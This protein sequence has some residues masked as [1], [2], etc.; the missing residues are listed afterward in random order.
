MTILVQGAMDSELDILKDY[1]KPVEVRT[2][3]GYEFYLCEYSNNKIILSK[4][5]VGIINAAIASTIGI[6]EFHPELVINQ[7]CAGAHRADIKRGDLIIGEKTVYINNF[8]TQAKRLG[9]GSDSLSWRPSNNN[10]YVI[11]STP[12][13]VELA[14]SVDYDGKKYTG[15]LGSGDLFSKEVDRINYM[16]ALFGELSEDMEAVATMKVCEA[17][18]IDKIAL[19]IISNNEITNE[20]FDRSV[21]QT[22]QQFVISFIDNI[23]KR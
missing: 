13:Y 7:G 8:R 2:I 21:C 22:L 11:E 14:E 16:H 17:F 10:S 6:H 20:S 19:R 9:E 23:I 5:E 4:T 18:N 12:K 3:S 15:I 1:F